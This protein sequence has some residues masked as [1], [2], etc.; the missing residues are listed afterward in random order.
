MSER[1]RAEQHAAHDREDRCARSDPDGERQRRGDRE[2]RR[3]AERARS[4][5]E[6][7][8]DRVEPAADALPPMPPPIDGGQLAARGDEVAEFGLRAPPG[9]VRQVSERDQFAHPTLQVEREL[10]IDVAV[11][12][13]A[14]H[15]RVPHPVALSTRNRALVY[16]ARRDDSARS[17]ARPRGV[18]L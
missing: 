11:N 4:V 12:S 6:I 2:G 5:P 10:V 16:R 15:H 8:S 9:R 13:P 3:P 17:L 1:K 7:L 18:S 14:R